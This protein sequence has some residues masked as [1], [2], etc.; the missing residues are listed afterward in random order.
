LRN[1]LG[2][3]LLLKLLLR[4][5]EYESFS[6]PYDPIDDRISS[7]GRNFVLQR[8]GG[9]CSNLHPV[10]S[11]LDVLGGDIRQWWAP[12]EHGGEVTG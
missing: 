9:Y 5:K 2:L 4:L 12:L 1:L 11:G 7:T 10:K 6:A 3:G 8:I